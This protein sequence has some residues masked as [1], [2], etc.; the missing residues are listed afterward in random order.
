MQET[1]KRQRCCYAGLRKAPQNRVERHKEEEKQK[2]PD[3]EKAGKVAGKPVGQPVGSE[4]SLSQHLPPMHDGMS[5]IVI[6]RSA[7]CDCSGSLSSTLIGQQRMVVMHLG[8]MTEC[9]RSSA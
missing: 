9:M 6:L 7:A 1:L 4:A 2:E 3:H 8:L 5:S